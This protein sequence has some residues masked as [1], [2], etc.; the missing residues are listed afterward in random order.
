MAAAFSVEA[1]V[2]R[3]GEEC[4]GDVASVLTGL[5][6]SLKVQLDNLN[7]ELGAHLGA[8]KEHT[9]E[10][11]VTMTEVRRALQGL[12]QH[13]GRMV[14]VLAVA[15]SGRAADELSKLLD[16]QELGAQNADKNDD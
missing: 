7:S 9:L 11:S 10:L 4:L 2:R 1:V 15:E 12:E 6:A 3:Q 16:L 14:D 13:V 5:D 8:T